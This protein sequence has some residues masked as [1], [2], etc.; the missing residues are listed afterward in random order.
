M[1]HRKIY[2]AI[3]NLYLSGSLPEHFALVAVGRRQKSTEEFRNEAFE[4]IGRFSRPNSGNE[5]KLK[6]LLSR[7]YYQEM[8]FY[9]TGAYHRFEQY[10]SKMDE[11]YGT[12][13]NRIYYLAVAPEHFEP[14]VTRLSEAGMVRNDRESWQ[15][16]VIEKPF[17]WDLQSATVLNQAITRVFDEEH[18]YRIDHYLGKEMLQNIMVI[19]FANAFFEPLWNNKYIDH[20][21]I[22]SSETVGVENRGGYYEGAGALRDMMQN[23]MLQLLMLTA[24]E[25]PISLSNQAIRDEKVKILKALSPM[26]P[27][28]VKQNVVR[29]QYTS[30]SIGGKKVPGYRQEERVSPDSSTETYMAMKVEIENFRWA[31]VPFYLRTG[32]RM[33]R[34]MTEIV[35]QFIRLPQILY[36]KEFSNLEPNTLIVRIQPEESVSIQFNGKK[37]GTKNTIIPARLDFCQNCEVGEVSP[38]AYER[39]LLD[40]MEGDSTLFTRWDEV[41]YSWKFVDGIAEA[42]KN[43]KRGPSF[44]P[45]GTWGPREADEL[46]EKDRRKWRNGD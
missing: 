6:E 10:L 9:E 1:S 22:T 18:I 25:P 12:Q 7:F 46:I 41:E 14:I 42:W 36:F 4:S 23:H 3:Y 43:E 19:R 13:G 39:L 34:K 33:P 29:G 32:K 44:Y 2:P 26:T 8:D 5:A 27:E 11:E 35:I 40:V 31:G 20:I 15:R 17:G 37:P 45:A 30:G 16:V 28:K 24:M 21:Q 38:D